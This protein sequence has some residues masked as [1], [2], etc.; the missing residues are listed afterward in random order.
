MSFGRDFLLK[1]IRLKIRKCVNE[2]INI[3]F[4]VL[5][6]R[7]KKK[8]LCVKDRAKLKY[9]KTFTFINIH[10]YFPTGRYNSLQT[11]TAF[12]VTLLL[13][14]LPK[15]FRFMLWQLVSIRQ[16]QVV[17]PVPSGWLSSPSWVD[18][19][20][21]SEL[22]CCILLRYNWWHYLSPN[23]RHLLFLCVLSWF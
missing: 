19:F 5:W 12:Q 10:P 9:K 8:V 7:E 3:G 18:L 14:S 16:I 20:T 21:P 2:K 4:L 17:C 22:I 15:R 6:T 13:F 1:K 23:T 11:I